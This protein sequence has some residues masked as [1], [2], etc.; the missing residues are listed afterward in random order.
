MIE[1][2]HWVL[3]KDKRDRTAERM[4]I[5]DV[6]KISDKMWHDLVD[7]RIRDVEILSAYLKIEPNWSVVD[8]QGKRP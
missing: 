1:H 4:A 3:G 5:A 8:T 2:R 7:E 6:D